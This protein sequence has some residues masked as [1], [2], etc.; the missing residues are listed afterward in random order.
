MAKRVILVDAAYID[1]VT[2]ALRGHFSAELKR[3]LPKADLAQWM[4]C[5]ALDC[6][7]RGDVQVIFLHDKE[8][9]VLSQFTPGNFSQELDG[10][11]FSEEGLGEFTIACCP[12]ERVTTLEDLCA[13]SLE[14]LLDDKNVEA[15]AAVYDF[16]GQTAV[17]RDLTKRIARLC[18]KS[19]QPVDKEEAP[20]TPKDVT[21]LSMTP[22]EGQ[23]FA[24]QILGYS[25]L[26]ALGIHPEEV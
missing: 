18:A 13:E 5:A 7:M 9:K 12:V 26:A 16:D 8:D 19:Q 20:K 10:K 6:E 4:V 2:A 15:I 11:A 14:A 24:L 25:I 22:I 23:G 3:E 17:S 21:L 1:R